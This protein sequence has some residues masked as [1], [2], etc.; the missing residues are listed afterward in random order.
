MSITQCRLFS[1][2]QWLRMT[3][4]S[5]LASHTRGGDVEARLPL[6]LVADFARALDHDD[7]FQS[8]PIVAFLQP[9]DIMDRGVGSGF[10]AAVIAVDRLIAADLC[11]LEAVGFLLGGKHLDIL[12]QGALIAFERE[13]VVGL[14]LQD[15]RSNIAL[16]SHGIDGH[17]GALDRHHGEERRDRDNF[18]R[19]FRHF[20]LPEH[21][22]LARRKG[23]NHMDRRFRAFLLVGTAQRLAV[24]GDHIRRRAGQ[25]RNP[26]HEAALELLGIERRK[27]IAEVI[28]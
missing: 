9:S 16:A 18:V 4:P 27:N 20:D 23:R 28:M 2:A 13:D 11:I 14:L 26:S 12:A 17:D 15:F 21:E 22:A 7:A 8:R 3:G 1:T 19:L 6:D 24:D 10:D 5:W 25:R